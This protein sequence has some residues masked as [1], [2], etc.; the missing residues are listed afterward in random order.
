MLNAFIN[1]V[2]AR[3]NKFLNRVDALEGGLDWLTLTHHAELKVEMDENKLEEAV[4]I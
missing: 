4:R 1:R 2:D 3:F